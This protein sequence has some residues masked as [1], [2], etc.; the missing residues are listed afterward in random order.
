MAKEEFIIKKK[1]TKN[2]IL[3]VWG[4]VT[5][6]AVLFIYSVF[7]ASGITMTTTDLGDWIILITGTIIWFL[8]G[9]AAIFG[10]FL[11]LDVWKKYYQ[12]IK[13]PKKCYNCRFY[14]KEKRL[15]KEYTDKIVIFEETCTNWLEKNNKDHFKLKNMKPCD[16]FILREDYIEEE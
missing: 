9:I 15:T 6:Y 13:I 2:W 1:Y 12:T 7:T 11:L 5:L 16:D 10:V 3:V 4:F 8:G 14:E